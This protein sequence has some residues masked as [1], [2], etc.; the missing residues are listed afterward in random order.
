[1][2]TPRE[3][4]GAEVGLDFGV[5]VDG[6]V[7]AGAGLEELAAGALGNTAGQATDD[8]VGLFRRTENVGNFADLKVPM[9]MRYVE[10]AAQDGGGGLQG[11]KVRIV[12]DPDLLGKNL[13]GYTHPDGSIDLYPDAFTDTEQLVKTLGHERTHTMQ[14]DI[15][16]HPNTL[17]DEMMP[18]LRLNAQAAHGIEDS[19]WQYYLQNNSGKLESFR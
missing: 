8:V 16:G 11:V 1:M 7:D 14:I 17:G 19:F 5:E 2:S 9:Q 6:Q 12:R 10:Q 13:Y 3:G 4:S 18:S 15:F